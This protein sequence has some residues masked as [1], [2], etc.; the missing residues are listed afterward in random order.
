MLPPR[1]DDYVQGFGVQ[2]YQGPQPTGY[3]RRYN[4]PAVMRPRDVGAQGDQWRTMLLDQLRQR[5]V[6]FYGA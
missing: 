5:G 3:R 1:L 4:Q 2:P 6:N